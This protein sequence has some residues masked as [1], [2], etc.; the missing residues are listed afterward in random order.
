MWS[1]QLLGVVATEVTAPAWAI[2]IAAVITLVGGAALGFYARWKRTNIQL[3]SEETQVTVQ[4]QRAISDLSIHLR[5]DAI[6]TWK[7]TADAAN[8]RAS[9]AEARADRK[10]EE[11]QSRMESVVT[12]YRERE[13]QLTKQHQE[14]EMMFQGIVDKLRTEY[15]ARIEA[16]ARRHEDCVRENGE[17]KGRLSQ[18]ESQLQEVQSRLDA[19]DMRRGGRRRDDPSEGGMK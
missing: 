1:T 14:R 16:I 5:D 15:D 7:N 10:E 19:R 18:V 3:A 2:A 8:L 13:S 12:R 11:W 9:E 6:Q 17:M 4:G